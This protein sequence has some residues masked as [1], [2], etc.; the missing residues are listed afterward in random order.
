MLIDTQGDAHEAGPELFSREELER[1]ADVLL[2]AAELSRGKPF[3]G[4]ETVLIEYDRL[5]RDL[6]EVLY[7]RILERGLVPVQHQRADAVMEHGYLTLANNKRLNI[8]APGE[9]ERLGGVNGLI[10]LL[11]PESLTHLQTIEPEL[12]AKRENAR[13]HI[14]EMFFFRELQHALGR[15]MAV[16]PTQALAD[17][18][19]ITLSDYAAQIRKACLL[20]SADPVREWKRYLREQRIVLDWLNG[21]RIKALHVHSRN[22][23]LIMQLGEQRKWLGLTGRNMPSFEIYTSPD[24]RY[25]EGVYAADQPLYVGGV[26][27]EGVRLVFQQGRVV[28][29]RCDSG[30]ERLRRFMALDDGVWRVGEFSMTSKEHSRISAFMAATLYDENI[31]GQAGNCHIALGASHPDAYSGEPGDFTHFCR[32]ELGFNESTQHW[33]LVNTKQKKV[34]ATLADGSQRVIYEDGLFTV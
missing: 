16:Y 32:H 17:A 14:Q 12:Q 22:A 31:G 1:Y 13:G 26:R 20:G 25:T 4:S 5:A 3:K 6:A 27:V 9:R 28:S 30:E 33:D 7:L 29:V 11:A 18:A 24:S 34:T 10:R 15:T 19:G 21:L 23:D 2:W 8:I